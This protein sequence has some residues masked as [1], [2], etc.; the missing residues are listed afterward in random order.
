MLHIGTFFQRLIYAT[1][2]CI[3]NITSTRLNMK[4]T[5]EHQLKSGKTETHTNSLTR[6]RALHMIMSNEHVM[7]PAWDDFGDT[8]K[9]A[10]VLQWSGVVVVSLTS[11]LAV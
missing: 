1:I 2:S 7:M 4:G 5:N 11:W 8:V 9:R 3:G 6:L 10:I